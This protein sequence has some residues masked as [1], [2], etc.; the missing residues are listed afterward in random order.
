MA[1][2]TGRM[3]RAQPMMLSSSV[4]AI[5][6]ARPGH[7]RSQCGCTCDRSFRRAH[8]WLATTREKRSVPAL[9]A[10]DFG[11]QHR[12]EAIDVVEMSASASVS[13]RL[14]EPAW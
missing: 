6:F 13:R 7:G 11:G 2:D 1:M 10:A 5:N 14:Q 3:I 4:V 8:V 12:A 9:T